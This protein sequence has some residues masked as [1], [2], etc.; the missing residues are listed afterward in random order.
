MTV[1]R[2]HSFADIIRSLL[3]R[4]RAHEIS[5]SHKHWPPSATAGGD[6][7]RVVP[8]AWGV[9]PAEKLPEEVDAPP[10][11]A[12]RPRRRL[13]APARRRALRIPVFR[14]P[15]PRGLPAT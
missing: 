2:S 9:E 13:P 12:P 5:K 14:M 3:V 8:T 1:F 6:L 15:V 7:Y 11:N 4:I 10:M